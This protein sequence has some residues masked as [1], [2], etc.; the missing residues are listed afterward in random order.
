MSSDPKLVRFF[1]RWLQEAGRLKKS[2]IL[3]DIFLSRNTN[4]IAKTDTEI[5]PDHA[6]HMSVRDKS[7]QE[8]NAITY[9][10]GVTRFSKDQFTRLYYIASPQKKYLEKEKGKKSNPTK[11][12]F[13]ILRLR[14]RASSAL[15][16][17]L[18]G[19]VEGIQKVIN[20]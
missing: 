8:Q 15:A 9:W 16:H 3:L 10:S 11:N 1:L 17:Q 7:L 13:G 2:E 12:N 5:G 19:W 18:N 6:V 20:I 14:V 4:T